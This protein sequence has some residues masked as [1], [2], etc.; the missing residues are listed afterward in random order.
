MVIVGDDLADSR[1]ELD[2]NVKFPSLTS[3]IVKYNKWA[4]ENLKDYKMVGGRIL[5]T[6]LT[7]QKLPLESTNLFDEKIVSE[8]KGEGN[9][10]SGMEYR[11][12]C[13]DG[14]VPYWNLSHCLTWKSA[15]P[16]LRVDELEKAEH[17]GILADRRFL[18]LLRSYCIVKN[19][20]T[21]K[22]LKSRPVDKKM[23][24]GIGS[25]QAAIAENKSR[26]IDRLDKREQGGIGS[27]QSAIAENG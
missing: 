19:P 5:E 27:L 20:R 1:F 18:D 23:E 14:T 13:G 3:D 11:R 16:D 21:Q 10:E 8:A 26:P 25:L 15:V 2:T 6:P 4:R 17:R 22:L 12:C 9:G 7:R 24:G